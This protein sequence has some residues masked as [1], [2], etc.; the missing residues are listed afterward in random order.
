[1]SNVGRPLPPPKRAPAN[2]A[3]AAYARGAAA[4]AAAGSPGAPSKYAVPRAGGPTP[5]IPPLDGPPGD[6]SQTMA[7][8]AQGQRRGPLQQGS[9]FGPP[10]SQRPPGP[11]LRPTDLLPAE[12]QQDP[13]FRHGAGSMYA[14]SQP[15]L[16]M[17]YGVMRSGQRVPPQQLTART[18]PGGTSGPPRQLRP[19]TIGDLKKLEEL[20][21]TS[22]DGE[23]GELAATQAAQEGPA[24]HASS[25]GSPPT[26]PGPSLTEEEIK[27]K[28]ANLDDFDLSTLHEAMIRDIIN[29]E[30]QRK[31]VEARLPPLSLADLVV[32]YTTTQIVPI[33][34]GVFEVE[35]ESLN[36]EDD[37]NLKR[38]LVEEAK[39]LRVDD[40]YLLNKYSYYGLTCAVRAVNKKPLGTHRDEQGNFDEKKLEEK[41]KRI[42]KMPLPM[43]A[44]LGPHY[45]WFD[46]RVRRL[47]VAQ[48]IKNG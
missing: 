46:Q 5:P 22:L 34:P 41:F 32:N 2:P 38:M 45:F 23:S 42:L 24:G 1:M 16:A 31:I 44:A 12:A 6:G 25:I 26:G 40:T 11:D 18:G 17:K 28:V 13:E 19:E 8:I 14:T 7:Q 10:Q 29:N 30:E 43:L 36:G 27:K 21:K 15:E 9:I 3:A 37:L 33:V 4:R 48:N 35:F 20:R 39:S 47:F